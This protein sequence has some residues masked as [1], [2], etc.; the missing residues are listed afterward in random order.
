[1]EQYTYEQLC[2]A[3]Q[4]NDEINKKSAETG[5][6]SDSPENSAPVLRED[7][8]LCTPSSAKGDYSTFYSTSISYGLEDLLNTS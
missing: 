1:M 5:L 2:E 6:D 3:V 8:V 7:V 4:D